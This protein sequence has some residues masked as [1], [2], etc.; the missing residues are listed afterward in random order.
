MVVAVVLTW[1]T[2]VVVV[3]IREMLV[4]LTW[5]ILGVFLTGGATKADAMGRATTMRAVKTVRRMVDLRFFSGV[6]KS[7]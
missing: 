2:L 5:G 3:L 4:V 1:E 7:F 6:F